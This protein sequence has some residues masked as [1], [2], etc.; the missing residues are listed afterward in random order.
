MRLDKFAHECHIIKD[1]ASECVSKL[2]RLKC[3]P[4]YLAS[5]SKNRTRSNRERDNAAS[6]M[7]SYY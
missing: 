6:N 3:R 7:T 2:M 5:H 4:Y 1:N